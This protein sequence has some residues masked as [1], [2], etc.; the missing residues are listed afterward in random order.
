MMITPKICHRI[1]PMGERR[2]RLRALAST[3]L[4]PNLATHEPL[5]VTP[6]LG[7]GL[8]VF[9][10]IGSTSWGDTYGGLRSDVPGNWHHGDDIFA[11]LGTPVVAVATGTLNRVGWQRVGGWRLWVRDRKGD[12]FYYAHLSGYTPLALH[13]KL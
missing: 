2:S 3:R 11:P 9:P 1:S 4:R 12:Q 6:K 8:Y 13:S 7:R 10:V 5:S